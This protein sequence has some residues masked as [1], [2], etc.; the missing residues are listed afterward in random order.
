[1][2]NKN[3]GGIDELSGSI[4]QHRPEFICRLTISARLIGFIYV[5]NPDPAGNPKPGRYTFPM[6]LMEASMVNEI[7]RAP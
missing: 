6:A 3:I 2:Y 5:S 1:M 7:V 4:F